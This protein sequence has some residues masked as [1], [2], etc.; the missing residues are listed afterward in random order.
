MRASAQADERDT[1]RLPLLTKN[2]IERI[3]LL[4]SLPRRSANIPPPRRK[5]KLTAAPVELLPCSLHF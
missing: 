1:S 4:T 2:F 5:M 3:S